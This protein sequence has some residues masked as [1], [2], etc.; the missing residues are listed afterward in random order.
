VA[1][2]PLPIEP[3][4]DLRTCFFNNLPGRKTMSEWIPTPVTIIE[5][6]EER[7]IGCG[8]CVIICGGEVFEIR[9]GK[10]AVAHRE[11]CLECG[12]CEVV[13]SSDALRVRVPAGGT[14]IIYQ[15]G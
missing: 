10:A 15:C 13:C 1:K 11:Q 2:K 9:E 6:D 7:C 12:N 14:G 5:I 8:S 4:N 3:L